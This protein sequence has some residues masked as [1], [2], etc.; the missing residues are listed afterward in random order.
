[1]KLRISSRLRLQ[2][3]QNNQEKTSKGI[4]K[5]YWKSQVFSGYFQEV[6]VCFQGVFPYALSGYAL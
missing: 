1:M 3:P 4:G 5:K 2:T 6:S